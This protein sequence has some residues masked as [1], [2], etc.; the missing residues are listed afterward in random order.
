MRRFDVW[1]VIYSA[2]SLYVVIVLA[3]CDDFTQDQQ[4]YYSC[5]ELLVNVVVLAHW[6]GVPMQTHYVYVLALS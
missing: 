4:C 1:L 3:L 2:G 6:L 5:I